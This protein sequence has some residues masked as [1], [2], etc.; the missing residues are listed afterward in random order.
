MPKIKVEIEVP[1]GKYCDSIDAVCPMC[2]D[3]EWGT[4]RCALFNGELEI[5][6]NYPRIIRCEECKQAEVNDETK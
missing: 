1:D 5:D 6:D 2:F 3:G 4:F